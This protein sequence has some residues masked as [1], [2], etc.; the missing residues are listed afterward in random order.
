MLEL[1]EEKFEFKFK[2]VKYVIDFPSVSEL[3]DYTEEVST[4]GKELD[5]VFNLL[6]KLGVKKAV[7]DK[8]KSNQLK[9]LVE[10]LISTKK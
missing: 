9:L 3:R 8:I 6:E 1:V 10:G 2:E 7:L 4:K 5:A